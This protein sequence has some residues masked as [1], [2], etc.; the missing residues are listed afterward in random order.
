MK[1]VLIILGVLIVGI[2]SAKEKYAT[3]SIFSKC[4]ISH[5]KPKETKQNM[6]SMQLNLM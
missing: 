6:W 2:F 3:T 5:I 1:K 4:K